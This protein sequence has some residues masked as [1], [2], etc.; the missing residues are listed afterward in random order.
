MVRLNE[1]QKK[2]VEKL[3]EINPGNEFFW[4]EQLN[5]PKFIKGELSEPSNDDP[6][7]IARNFLQDIGDLL[8]MQEGID[9]RLEF[10]GKDTDKQGFHHVSF[11]QF[12]NGIPVFEGSTQIHINP[13]GEVIAYKDYRLPQINISLEPKITKETAI[14]TALKN[15]GMDYSNVK[16]DAKLSI[17][18]DNEKKPHLAWEVKLVV[19][20]ELGGRFYFIDAQSG[21]I[22]YKFAQ[23]RGLFS[24]MTYTAKNQEILP[25]TLLIE[26]DQISDDD[27]AQAAHDHVK[28][29]YDYYKAT[30]DRD[31]YDGQGSTLVS[32]VHFKKNY[33]NAF[34]A[35]EYNQMVYGD[36]D[37][38]LYK[39]LSFALDVVGHELTH[40][41]TSRTARFVYAEEAGALDESFADFF[42]VMVSNDDPIA[43]W[44]IGEEVYTPY[45]SG[46]A[47]RDLSDPPKYRQPDHMDDFWSLSP[48]ELPDPDKNDDGWV[49]I[50]SG[51][52]N[53]GAYLVVAGGN[54]HGI[55]IEGIGR[56][57]AEQ[58][59]YL[60][61][62]NY[63]LSSTPSRWTFNQARMALL[64]AC[65]QLYGD[66]GPEYKCVKNAMAA[67]GI[68][69]PSEEYVA[70]QKEVSP[71]I[72]IPD[73]DP[74]GIQSVINIP[75]QG[76]LKEDLSVNVNIGHPYIGDL[77]IT[78]VSP[79]GKSAVL[80]DREYGTFSDLV[81][82]YDLSTTPA[83]KNFVGDEIQGDWVLQV[84][85]LAQR[86]TGN[87]L[88]WG[89]RLTGQVAE[90]KTIKEEA[91]P[92]LPI[93]DKNTKGIESSI[94]IDRSGKIINLS[95]S[96][97]ITHTYIGD[98]KV[99]LF[100]PS[101]NQITLHNRT[102]SSRNDI[103]KTYT[104]ESNKSLQALVG[105]EMH[106]NWKLKVMD[107]AKVDEGTLNNWGIEI[108]YE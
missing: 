63:L 23:I 42:G 65:R 24:R 35:E 25:G 33:N 99:I 16:T 20:D 46:D 84:A 72:P 101:G 41:V 85:D 15:I 4:D 92:N 29:V 50:N 53:K 17:F 49:H 62:T 100:A 11:H 81:T 1:K 36:G 93:P 64:N 70:I 80:H 91:S 7:T 21:Q 103:R 87:L 18:R 22:L 56:K 51:I 39:P 40:A 75:E 96:L 68:G 69:A 67:I 47:T 105:K 94:H 60:A 30:F 107:L 58:I 9:E 48:G 82:K 55:Q 57:K 83:L 44:E 77:R 88:Q 102:G 13:R 97:D 74:A 98:L 61:L 8:D 2:V 66:T 43:S 52:F 90:K 78:L 10:A 89:I 6:E 5:I 45:I 59:F 28:E 104:I 76:I 31:S 95:V 27:V 108:A 86:D 38:R 54:H 79:T 71:N 26:D 32:T 19:G 14:E 3:K 37:G 12:L 106:G 73:N 34:W